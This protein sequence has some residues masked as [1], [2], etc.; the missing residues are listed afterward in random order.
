LSSDNFLTDPR[1]CHWNPSE[2]LCTGGLSDAPTCLTMPQVAALR[3]FYQG[4]TNPRTGK[5]I[6]GGQVLGS[7]SNSGYPAVIPTLVPPP[8]MRWTFGTG[9]DWR[10]FDFDQDIDTVD[11][12]LAARLNANTAD[13]EEFKSHGGKLSISHGFADPVVPTLNTI[14][15]YERLIAGQMPR[16]RRDA[17]AREEALRRTQ[18]FA[19]LFLLPGVGHCAGGAGPDTLVVAGPDPLGQMVEW[20]EQDIAPDQFVFAKI[21]N[22]A[23]TF[24]RPVCPYPALPRYS[25]MGDPTRASSFVC[26]ADKDRNHN[27]PPA[28]RYLDDGDNYP[29]VP[30]A[31]TDDHDHSRDHDDR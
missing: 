22:G 23:T 14:A 17:A 13:L 15:Y 3:K 25:G 19:R 29:I 2:L 7:E 31:P 10:T 24:T 11:S 9:F 21:V 6:F 5:R 16:G 4:P 30:I 8:A 20:V 27:Q 12:D 18:E 1:D 28:P 26:V